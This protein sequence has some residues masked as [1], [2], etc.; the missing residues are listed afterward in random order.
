MIQLFRVFVMFLPIAEPRAPLLQVVDQI[1]NRVE[2]DLAFVVPVTFVFFV[3]LVILHSETWCDNSERFWVMRANSEA[4][5]AGRATSAEL[6][7]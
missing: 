6:V 3:P 7:E 2:G 1:G 4:V 5:S